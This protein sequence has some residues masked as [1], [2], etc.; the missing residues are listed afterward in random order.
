MIFLICASLGGTDGVTILTPFQKACM[1]CVIGPAKNKVNE[2]TQWII[3][4]NWNIIPRR[5]EN[6]LTENH[7]DPSNDVENGKSGTFD[8]KVK[9]ILGDSI[10]LPPVVLE[11]KYLSE[12]ENKGIDDLGP[13]IFY[14][15]E[16]SYRIIQ[17][18]YKDN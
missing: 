15:E 10:Y 17:E 1:R 18:D 3:K 8:K 14:G 4:D 12:D 16:E 2:M 6:N 11:S 5:N 13:S 9:S 7:L